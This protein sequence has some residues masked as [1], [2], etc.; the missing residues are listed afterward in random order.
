[1]FEIITKL[2]CFFL[3]C[4]KNS[5]HN[6]SKTEYRPVV[7]IHGLNGNANSLNT[8]K[9]HIIN[10]HPTTEIILPA[11]YENIESYTNLWKQV[12][13]YYQIIKKIPNESENGINIV[14]H[15][16]GGIIARA[17]IE[18][19]KDLRVNNFIALS[20]PLNGQFG[21]TSALNW[22]PFWLRNE[23]SYLFYTEEMQ[24][25]CSIAG[26]WKDPH[27]FPKYQKYSSFLANLNNQSTSEK[28]LHKFNTQW[29]LNFIKLNNFVMIGGPQDGVITPWQSS[30]MGSYLEDGI[31]KNNLKEIPVVDM[32]SLKIYKDDVFGL[33]TLD[34]ANKIHTYTFD[35]VEHHQ[36]TRNK[37]IFDQ[38]ILPW[39]D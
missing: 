32:R 37:T 38:A 26:Y 25:L 6:Q 36:W 8:L 9:E 35:G 34:K 12:D 18:T 21:D 39:L 19:K 16:Q 13:A 11:I 23:A 27:K 30:Q 17:I 28:E 15:S 5:E 24:Y 33:K 14:A 31:Y 20:S 29:K 22:L 7:L 10:E 3:F 1:M 4:K 2:L